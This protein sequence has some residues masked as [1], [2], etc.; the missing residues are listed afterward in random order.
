[1]PNCRRDLLLIALLLPAAHALAAQDTTARAL[2]QASVVFTARGYVYDSVAGRPI[3]GA[4]VQLA[5]ADSAVKG[6][7][8]AAQSDSTGRFAVS[9]VVPGRYLVGFFDPALDTLG[10][11]SNG[12]PIDIE[13]PN[14]TIALA[15]P[16]ARTLGAAFC[17]SAMASSPEFT[18]LYGK[19]TDAETDSGAL[20]G[21]VSITWAEIRQDSGRARVVDRSTFVS[22]RQGETYAACG[23]PGGQPLTIRAGRGGDSSGAVSIRISKGGMR[24]LMLALATTGGRGTLVARVTDEAHLPIAG[25]R[26]AFFRAQSLEAVSDAAGLFRLDSLPV[27][28]QSIQVRAIGHSPLDAVVQ[29]AAHHTDSTTFVLQKVTVLPSVQSTAETE[30][31]AMFQH[32]KQVALQGIFIQPPHP[33][34]Y[35]PSLTICQLVLAYGAARP[36]CTGPM[37][38]IP[39]WCASTKGFILNGKPVMLPFE[40]VDPKDIIGVEAYSSVTR[41]QPNPGSRR[42]PMTAGSQWDTWIQSMTLCPVVVW[43]K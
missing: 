19:V 5:G 26:A 38:D 22:V 34:D 23:L 18:L 4:N 29:V 37:S 39:G 32:D 10:I 30:H 27:G 21:S 31:L 13:G 12:Q 28:T 16:S 41:S 36:P 1:M 20:G 2:P 35:S 24:H 14:L 43:T 17:G 11:Q 8:Y 33:L 3:S 25:A 15:V 42:V 40:S 9:G 6:K 7:R